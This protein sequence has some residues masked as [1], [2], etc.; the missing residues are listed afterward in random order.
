[1]D[2]SFCNTIQVFL[3]KRLK[4]DEEGN[5]AALMRLFEEVL[6]P[7]HL[8][9]GKPHPSD[10]MALEDFKKTESVV[11]FRGDVVIHQEEILSLFIDD[12]G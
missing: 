11:F 6:M 7:G 10:T 12:L 2:K 5:T 3:K 9:S 1:M 8:D 4:A